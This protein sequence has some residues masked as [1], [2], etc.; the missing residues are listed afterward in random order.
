MKRLLPKGTSTSQDDPKFQEDLK[1]ILE[2]ILRKDDGFVNEKECKFYREILFHYI[3]NLIVKMNPELQQRMK[4][5]YFKL[6][7]L[8][9]GEWCGD[10]MICAAKAGN[11]RMLKFGLE[12]GFSIQS[13]VTVNTRIDTPL[14]ASFVQVLHSKDSNEKRR[15]I[16][17]FKW[18]RRAGG[19]IEPRLWAMAMLTNPDFEAVDMLLQEGADINQMFMP[20]NGILMKVETSPLTYMIFTMR[21]NENDNPHFIEEMVNRGAKVGRRNLLSVVMM[22]NLKE[23]TKLVMGLGYD[24]NQVDSDGG[25]PFLHFLE[26]GDDDPGFAAYAIE[27]GA[28]PR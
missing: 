27:L 5:V 8:Q 4:E 1:A 6:K 25:T 20:I 10:A 13:A 18:I 15:N 16:I 11:I 24:I 19:V 28:D 22:N 12:L 23:C 17:C 3:D 7:H 21:V 26:I 9:S 2:E 14:S